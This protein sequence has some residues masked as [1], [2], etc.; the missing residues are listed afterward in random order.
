VDDLE[1]SEA[2]HSKEK[3]VEA[4]LSRS[5]QETNRLSRTEHLRRM[6]DTTSACLI[7]ATSCTIDFGAFWWLYY[8]DSIAALLLGTLFGL[9]SAS[10][11]VLEY[12]LLLRRLIP[13]RLA[14]NQGAM[15]SSL[16]VKLLRLEQERC[17]VV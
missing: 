1:E 4:E 2:P 17:E 3:V 5:R 13:R 9:I 6:R 14:V 11:G 16:Y 10:T 7:I 8:H 15:S 12:F